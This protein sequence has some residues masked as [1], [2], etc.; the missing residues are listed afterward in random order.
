MFK[1]R[2]FENIIKT[3]V[4]SKSFMKLFHRFFGINTAF[5]ISILTLLNWLAHYLYGKTF[6]DS[7]LIN[8][9]TETKRI[10]CLYELSYVVRPR[11]R[12][13]KDYS[14]SRILHLVPVAIL[15]T[16]N[17]TNCFVCLFFFL[18]QLQLISQPV[19]VICR[20]R[21]ARVQTTLLASI[22]QSMPF[23][24]S[25][26]HF[27]WCWYCGK[28]Q[29]ECSLALSILLSTTIRVITVVKICCGLTW[30]CLVS[31]QLLWWRIS[32]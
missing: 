23:S 18:P 25:Q 21:H 20:C 28:K 22:C 12:A 3:N 14:S 27:L 31:T 29:I 1:L 15:E 11:R 32:L 13:T 7:S 9:K 17:Q 4:A 8:V 26:K 5:W 6:L 30:L 16:K 24:S 19:W 10:T 2:L